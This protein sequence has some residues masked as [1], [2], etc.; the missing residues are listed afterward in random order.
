MTSAG[1]FNVS[2]P[3]VALSLHKTFEADALLSLHKT[4]AERS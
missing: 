4:F 2:V 1:G 3:A